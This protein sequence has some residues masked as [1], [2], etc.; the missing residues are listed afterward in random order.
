MPTT[1]QQPEPKA[2][3]TPEP[4]HAAALGDAG[5]STD[6]AVHQLLAQLEIHERNGDEDGVKTVT[7]R[8]AD[9]GYQA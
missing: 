7:G 8:L 5:A 4:A 6:P 1:K 3:P 9:L 2:E